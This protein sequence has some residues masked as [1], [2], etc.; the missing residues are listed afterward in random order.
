MRIVREISRPQTLH[1][2]Q[3]RPRPHI[4][5]P[6]EARSQSMGQPGQAERQRGNAHL[7]LH[8]PVTIYMNQY[9]KHR[10]HAV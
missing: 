7:K 10:V 6:T 5:V 3:L 8:R 2:V 4:R 9:S 1:T